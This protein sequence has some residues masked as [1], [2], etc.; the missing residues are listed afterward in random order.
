ML[1]DIILRFEIAILIILGHFDLRS[2]DL[3]RLTYGG[4]MI[5]FL[6]PIKPLII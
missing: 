1:L 4:F 3:G 5:S 6:F 2:L